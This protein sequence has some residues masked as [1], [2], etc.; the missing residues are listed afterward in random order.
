MQ[1]FFYG[2]L[3]FYMILLTGSM[4]HVVMLQVISYYKFLGD[5]TDDEDGHGAAACMACESSPATCRP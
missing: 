3:L 4:F 2:G 5:W 1:D